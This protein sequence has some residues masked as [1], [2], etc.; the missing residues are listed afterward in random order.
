MRVFTKILIW[1][2]IVLML[3]AGAFW[4]YCRV[5]NQRSFMAG[6]T[7]LVLRIQHR[8]EKFTDLAVCEAYISEK[9]ESNRM[10]VVIEKAKFGISLREERLDALQAY[11]YNDQ[12]HPKQT[13]FYNHGGAYINQ[14]NPQQRT[15]AART[16]RQTGAEF[17]LMVYPKEPVYDCAAAYDQC[18][19]YYRSYL[20][21]HDCGKVVFMGDSAGG[22]LALGLAEVIRDEGGSAPEE[23]ILISPWVDV[24][25]SNT[26]MADYVSLDPMLGIPGLRRMGEVWAGGLE[27]TDPKVSPIYGE[28]AGLAPVTLTAG[29][30]EILYP[31]LLLLAEKLE[32]AGVP[33][34]LITGERMI[35][36]YP[37]CPVP[38]AKAAQKAIWS[39]IT[40]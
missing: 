39:A 30:W 22:G 35:H 3:L 38:E 21:N 7:D 33:C 31:D 10:P 2:L 27:M 12:E 9:A 17:V 4:F 13:V 18:L 11:I 24:T 5:I 28:L 16:A 37:I 1:F 19:A 14:P 36:C 40:R 34:S 32:Q 15:M 25:M 6:V 29:T 8:N 26:E 23:L 20:E